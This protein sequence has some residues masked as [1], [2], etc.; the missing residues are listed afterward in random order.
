MFLPFL[1][2]FFCYVVGAIPTAY[3]VMLVLRGQDIRTMGSGNSGATNAG[4]FLGR[5]GFFF[6]L[7]ADAL[8]AYISLW[9]AHELCSTSPFF[10]LLSV[11]AVYVGN[12][13]S[14]FIGF[15]GGKG[16]ATSVG[17]MT[18]LFPLW[19]IVLNLAL[20][21]SVALWARRVDVASLSAALG[22][23]LL[24]WLAG[25]SINNVFTA[26]AIAVWIWIRHWSNIVSLA[27]LERFRR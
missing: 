22:A 11:V 9:V 26:T 14:P 17:I 15:A 10:F 21:V 8:K 7:L 19:V 12:A 2:L 6:V 25:H 23:P 24:L 16:V 13:Y 18:F 4:R 3:L 1:S 5:S 20:F 27:H